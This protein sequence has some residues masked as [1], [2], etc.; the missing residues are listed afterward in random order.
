MTSNVI[1]H[2][3]R[4]AA[5][6]IHTI[7]LARSPVCGYQNYTFRSDDE[8]HLVVVGGYTHNTK[9]PCPGESM[10]IIFSA[11]LVSKAAVTM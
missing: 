9:N 11:V 3:M 4:I 6:C 7:A 1:I 2:I 5:Q 10:H 8:V